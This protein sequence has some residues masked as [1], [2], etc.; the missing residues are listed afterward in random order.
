MS[1]ELITERLTDVSAE[2]GCYE[3]AGYCYDRTG[4]P[5]HEANAECTE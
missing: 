3:V 1:D 2:C 5:T 4:E